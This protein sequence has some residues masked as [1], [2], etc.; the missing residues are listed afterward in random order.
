VVGR[1]VVAKVEV[2]KAV[3]KAVV[4][5]ESVEVPR[6]VEVTMDWAVKAAESGLA[7]MVAEARA[8]VEKVAEMEE[9]MEEAA[10]EAEREEAMAAEEAVTAVAERMGGQPW[11]YQLE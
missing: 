9:E 7:P 8:E 6:A 10:K 4:R 11:R 2:V 5:A 1:A 3:V